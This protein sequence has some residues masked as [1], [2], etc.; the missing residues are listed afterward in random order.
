MDIFQGLEISVF[1]QHPA[2]IDGVDVHRIG[3]TGHVQVLIGEMG[4]HI[5]HRPLHPDR[6]LLLGLLAADDLVKNTVQLPGD[7]RQRRGVDDPGPGLQLYQKLRGEI[8][9]QTVEYMEN[10]VA[11]LKDHWQY[12]VIAGG[13]LTLLGAIFNW[14]WVTSPDG[15]RPNG[16][17]RFI[18]DIFGQGGYR[19]FMG[20]LGVV[21]IAC[22]IFFLFVGR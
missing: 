13:G 2:E 11:Y 16:P 21:I 5:L 15:E 18:Y 6:F 9:L 17:G 1:F 12:V 10:V 20:V 14:R 4:V 22:G 8:L 3:H 7:L 19:V